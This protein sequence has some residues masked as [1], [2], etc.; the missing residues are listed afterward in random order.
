[1]RSSLALAAAALAAVLVAAPLTAAPERTA[2]RG[3]LKGLYDQHQLLYG[4]PD[5]VF[6]VFARLNTKVVR[7]NLVWGGSQGVAR[8]RPANAT[9]PADPA[10]E[11]GVYDRLAVHAGRHNI[12]MV[13]SVWGTP[14]WANGGKRQRVAPRNAAHLR[15]FM[16][17][18]ARRYGGTYE[19]EDGTRL[20][21]VHYFLAWNEPNNPAFLHPQFRRAGRRF[22]MQ[23]PRDYARICNAVVRGVRAARAS[24][25]VGCGVTGPRGNNLP[26]GLRPAISPIY[27]LRAMH[28]AGARG[29]DAYAHHPYPGRPSETPRTR[30]Q[31]RV[32]PTAITLGNLDVLIREVTRRWGRKPIWITEYGYE[33]RP[34]DRIF[35]VSPR[36]QAQY[37]SQSYAIARRNPRVQMFIWFLL[38]DERRLSGWQSGLL[39]ANGRPKPAFTTFRRL[40]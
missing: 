12:R 18:A 19:L 17:A 4:D 7:V 35:G 24:Q 10:Y 26:R 6:P 3:M 5:K 16:T 34:P 13:L 28:A 31:G 25:K 14:G 36:L 20:P 29:F 38:R 15:A 21:K 40:R 1:M 37:L 2:A 32:G 33:T 23:S 22:V 11:W 8:R 30:L 39:R 27:F 9:D